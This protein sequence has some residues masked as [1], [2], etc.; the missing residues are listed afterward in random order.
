MVT[1]YLDTVTHFFSSAGPDLSRVGLWGSEQAMQ[2]S[3]NLSSHAISN[4]ATDKWPDGVWPVHNKRRNQWMW[5]RDQIFTL[6]ARKG[7]LRTNKRQRESNIQASLWPLVWLTWPAQH[8]CLCTQSSVR[9]SSCHQSWCLLQFPGLRS[10][11]ADRHSLSDQTGPT[12]LPFSAPQRPLLWSPHSNH[13]REAF[14]SVSK[15]SNNQLKQYS[16]IAVFL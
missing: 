4:M 9:F 6:D 5:C 12:C 10:L 7:I 14:K 16:K 11:Q 3:N 2:Q 1:I 15:F 13:S 8:S